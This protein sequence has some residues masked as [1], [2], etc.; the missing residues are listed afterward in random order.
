MVRFYDEMPV[1]AGGARL[2]EPGRPAG[3]GTGLARLGQGRV[4][5]RYAGVML[6]L[7]YLHRVGAETIFATVTGG[8]ARRYDDLAVL[9]TATVGFALGADTVEGTEH[10]RRAEAGAVVGLTAIPELATLRSRLGALGDGSD[11]LG[12]QRAFA[13]AMISADPAGDPVYFV[14]DHFVAYSGA[15][16][17]A[18]GSNTKR[19]H[20]QPGRD[21]TLLVDARGRAVLFGS[22][23]PTGLA[24]T[25]PGVL[26]QLREVLGPN[27]PILLG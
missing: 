11:P 1:G 19:R 8:P 9:T 18:K 10:L 14:D 24:S 21:D 15:R 26:T 27:A 3:V 25:L 20:A 22:G 17:V 12:L 2:G 5:S 6:L 4:R 13:A 23:E 16:P 7:P